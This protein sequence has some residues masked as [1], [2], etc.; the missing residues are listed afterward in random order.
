MGTKKHQGDPRADS[1][2]STEDEQQNRMT[3]ECNHVSKAVD[4]PK[5]RKNLQKKTDGNRI[6]FHK[7]CQECVKSNEH[8]NADDMSDDIEID[9]SLWMC[10]KC[11]NHGCGRMRNQHALKHFNKPR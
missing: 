3:A 10:L 6:E 7:D 8:S 2:E 9:A 5:I 11:G 1:D 4:L